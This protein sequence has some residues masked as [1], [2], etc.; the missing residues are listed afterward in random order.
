MVVSGRLHRRLYPSVQGS[1]NQNSVFESIEEEI[2]GDVCPLEKER[3]SQSY[4]E[5]ATRVELV[6]IS[7][8]S[9]R[10]ISKEFPSIGVAVT[11]LF[12]NCRKLTPP[13]FTERKMRRHTIPVQVALEIL[14]I[15]ET[16]PTSKLH[17]VT[18]DLSIGGACIILEETSQAPSPRQLIGKS[19]NI[20]MSPPNDAM[21]LNIKGS[22]VWSQMISDEGYDSQAIGVEFNTMSPHLSGLLLVFADNL[23]HAR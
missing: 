10:D 19:V 20:M 8:G 5:T 9:L 2:F 4:T 1:E 15:D 21:T 17:G 11:E 6:K 16:A 22:I 13:P 7:K 14:E 12:D 3:Y 23:Y 18:R